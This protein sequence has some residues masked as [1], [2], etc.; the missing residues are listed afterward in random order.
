[1][2]HSNLS[3]VAIISAVSVLLVNACDEPVTEPVSRAQPFATVAA[4]Y[5]H[6]CAL[7]DAGTAFCWG[8]NE[9]GQLGMAT[10]TPAAQPTALAVDTDLKFASITAGSS[11]PVGAQMPAPR[12]AG[13]RTLVGTLATQQPSIDHGPRKWPDRL[14]SRAS[15]RST[16][17]RA[18]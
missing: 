13:A 18:A 10:P 2:N 11:G 14:R 4:G 9:Y 17:K 12:T 16:R 7:T 5:Y 1:M 6:T 3:P 15:A 8:N